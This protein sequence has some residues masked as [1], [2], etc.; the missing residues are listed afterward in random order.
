MSRS[1]LCR[2]CGEFHPLDT[3][4]PNGCEGHFG[5]Q[6]DDAPMIRSDGM[7]PIR[8]MADGKMYDSRSG[9]YASVKRAG[10]EIVGNDRAPFERRPEFNPGRVGPDIK[11]A[12]EQLRSR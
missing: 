1:R 3:A 5:A 7:E 8:S 12:I 9:Y 11:R 6:A 10:C 2:I 4:W